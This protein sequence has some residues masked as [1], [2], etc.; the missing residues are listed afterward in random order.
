MQ[1]V[2]FHFRL[3]ETFMRFEVLEAVNVL[4]VVFGTAGTFT[5]CLLYFCFTFSLS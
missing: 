1:I 5:L 4:V 2:G 3:D